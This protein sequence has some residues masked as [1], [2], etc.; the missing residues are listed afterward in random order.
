MPLTA[1]LL[2][3]TSALTGVIPDNSCARRSMEA[4]CQPPGLP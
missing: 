2:H 4:L 1:K 3:A